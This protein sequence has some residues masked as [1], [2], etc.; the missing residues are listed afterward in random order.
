VAFSAQHRTSV[1]KYET[2]NMLTCSEA[3]ATLEQGAAPDQHLARFEAV[4][5]GGATVKEILCTPEELQ[6]CSLGVCV[7]L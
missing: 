2:L 5:T 6:V 7:R 1:W 3:A 4:L